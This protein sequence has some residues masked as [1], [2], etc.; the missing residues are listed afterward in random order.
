MATNFNLDLEQTFGAD[1]SIDL[2]A[3]QA[4]EQK[5]S[6]GERK[7]KSKKRQRREF[8]FEAREVP[9]VKKSKKQERA[10]RNKTKRTEP[11]KPEAEIF[12]DGIFKLV[13]QDFETANQQEIERISDEFASMPAPTTE[14]YWNDYDVPLPYSTEYHVKAAHAPKPEDIILTVTGIV[15]LYWIKRGDTFYLVDEL[16]TVVKNV[17]PL[18]GG[19]LVSV[20]LS[21][22]TI[23]RSELPEE[24]QGK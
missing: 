15:W 8:D 21:N 17:S 11:N 10:E 16:G 13:K 18:K 23:W 12:M 3:H 9:E 24:L 2:S 5:R 14:V 6:A 19:W 7:E 20:P 1:F 22:Y 4:R